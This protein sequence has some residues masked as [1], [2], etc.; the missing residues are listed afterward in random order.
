MQKDVNYGQ[1]KKEEN[2]RKK[3]IASTTSA[4]ALAC[5]HFH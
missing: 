1:I 4:L 3:V 5:I 2:K